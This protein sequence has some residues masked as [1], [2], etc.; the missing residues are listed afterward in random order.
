MLSIA[1][2]CWSHRPSIASTRARHSCGLVL[3]SLIAEAAPGLEGAR[4]CTPAV[5]KALALDSAFEDAGL[6]VRGAAP[7][8]RGDYGAAGGQGH[9]GLIGIGHGASCIW[10]R[11]GNDV[12]VKNWRALDTTWRAVFFSPPDAQ[13]SEGPAR[14][15]RFRMHRIWQHRYTARLASARSIPSLPPVPSHASSILSDFIYS[16]SILSPPSLSLRLVPLL[17]SAAG[18]GRGD[19]GGF[20]ERWLLIVPTFPILQSHLPARLRSLWLLFRSSAPIIREREHTAAMGASTGSNI[21]VN[22]EEFGPP[23]DLC[24]SVRCLDRDGE[25]KKEIG[26]PFLDTG[27]LD[28]EF[29]RG[30]GRGKAVFEGGKSYVYAKNRRAL[31]TTWRA[32][33]FRRRMLE[34]LAVPPARIWQHGYTA[35]L[36]SARSIPS[37]PPVPSH[38]SPILSDF[39]YSLSILSPPSLSLRLVPLLLSAAGHGRGDDGRVRYRAGGAGGG[40]S[41]RWCW[42]FLLRVPL[43]SVKGGF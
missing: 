37:L 9:G 39:I 25:S 24:L 32:V 36:A 17:F 33:F 27:F 1:G 10:G 2:Q 11:E 3:V 31:D 22:V 38:A 30:R 7:G 18:H 19:N 13:I 41:D 21:V 15:V 26:F 43:S 12:Y 40:C 34:S 42:D 35:R 4:V 29:W 23:E 20:C 8:Y 28:L 5:Y 16:L 6:E 14:E